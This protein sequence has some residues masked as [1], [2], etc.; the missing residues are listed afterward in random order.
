V[1]TK[2]LFIPIS[3]TGSLIAGLVGKKLF[4][5]V[6]ARVDEEEPPEAEHRDVSWWKLVTANAIQG[7]IFRA[8]R[9]STD[10]AS[11]LFFYRATG[12]WPGEEEPDPARF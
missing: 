5:F 4:D 7:A 1:V 9:A 6:W 8:A 12:V 10:R 11:R 3:I 2:I